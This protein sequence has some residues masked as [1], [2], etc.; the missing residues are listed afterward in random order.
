VFGDDPAVVTAMVRAAVDGYRAGGVIPA[1]G[2]FPGIGAASADPDSATATVGLSLAELRR[3]DLRPFAAVA[4][5]AP[6]IVVSNAVYAA[7][8]GVTPAVLEPGI[9]AALLRRDLRFRGVMMT[10]DLTATA[11][12]LA[13]RVDNTAVAALAAGADLL[14]VSGGGRDQEMAYR[15]VVRAVRRGVISRERL[16]VSV[17]RV[18]ALKRRYGLLPAPP[19]VRRPHPRP[20]RRPAPRH[21]VPRHAP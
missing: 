8:D 5:S 13:K 14:Y 1:V 9:T 2:H 18:L 7:F 3:R 20:A 10:D 19:A 15:A 17:L 4:R 11:A 16:R 12:I 6:V 21:A